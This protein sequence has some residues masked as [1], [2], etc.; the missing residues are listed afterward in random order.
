VEYTHTGNPYPPRGKHCDFTAYMAAPEGA[1][2][3][4]G[5]VRVQAGAFESFHDLKPFKDKIS[6][7]VCFAGGD[8]AIVVADAHGEFV[9]AT[10]I[11]ARQ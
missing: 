6:P 9:V 3:E 4:L 2:E 10:V 7:F 11:R 1:Y 5:V 8:G